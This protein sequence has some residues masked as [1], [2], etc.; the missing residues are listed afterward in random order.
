MAISKIGNPIL[1]KEHTY[2]RRIGRRWRHWEFLIGI[3]LTFISLVF[4]LSL[5]NS[6]MGYTFNRSSRNTSIFFILMAVWVVH[7]AVII[8]SILAGVSVISREHVGQT[9]DSLVLTGVS[10]R[11]ILFGK[12]RAAL[13]TVMPWMLILGVLRV[14]MLPLMAYYTI[15]R[16]ALRCMVNVASSYAN[17]GTYYSS[18]FC[19]QTDWVPWSWLSAPLLAVALTM[20]EVVACVSLGLAASAITRRS[21]SAAVLAISVRFLPV[22]TFAG[23]AIYENGDTWFFRYL[24]YSPFTIADGGMSGLIQ[25]INPTGYRFAGSQFDALPGLIGVTLVLGAI[26]LGSWYVALRVLRRGGALSH[27]QAT[28]PLAQEFGV[29]RLSA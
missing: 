7:T 10:V 13:R 3:F 14:V 23:F 26:M 16:I 19:T 6:N 21:V 25:L 15:Q 17:S 4:I 1:H 12:L 11:Q 27:E 9:W 5:L 28:E 29:F 8:R 18:Y 20:L 24:R 2:F 22:A